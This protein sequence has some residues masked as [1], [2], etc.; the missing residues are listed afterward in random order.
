MGTKGLVDEARLV[1]ERRAMRAS[2]SGLKIERARLGHDATLLGA[3]FLVDELQT[4][5]IGPQTSD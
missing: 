1:M 4:S 2:V 3:A 5:D